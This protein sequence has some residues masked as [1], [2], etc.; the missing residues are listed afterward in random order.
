MNET[1]KDLEGGDFVTSITIDSTHADDFIHIPFDGEPIHLKPN[2]DAKC[3]KIDILPYEY[4][5]GEI[6]RK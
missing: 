4:K 5:N 1:R 3:V 2:H 6:V